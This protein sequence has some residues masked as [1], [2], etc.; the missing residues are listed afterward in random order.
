MGKKIVKHKKASYLKPLLLSILVFILLVLSAINILI[1]LTPP[2][3]AKSDTL[4]DEIVYWQSV[5]KKT[6]SYREGYLKIAELEIRRGNRNEAYQALSKAQ[7][8]NP[9]KYFY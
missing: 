3:N 9:N 1:F 8:T 6:P 4:D 5:V 7:N 2:K